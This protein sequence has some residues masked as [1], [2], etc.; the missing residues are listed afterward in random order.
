MHSPSSRAGA[1]SCE[2]L[3]CSTWLLCQ[4]AWAA[5]LWCPTP[6]PLTPCLG[7]SSHQIS[8]LPAL[9]APSPA[10]RAA[11]CPSQQ[12]PHSPDSHSGMCCLSLS[13]GCHSCCPCPPLNTSTGYLCSGSFWIISRINPF[14]PTTGESRGKGSGMMH[15]DGS[16]CTSLLHFPPVP[17]SLGLETAARQ[18]ALQ[19]SLNP[20]TSLRA[21]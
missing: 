20:Q 10:P 3:A 12:V 21:P 13:P 14:A 18:L 16:P 7:S 1:H 5:A 17:L 9:A 15:K 11:S 8:F 19:G 2:I 6:G 4:H